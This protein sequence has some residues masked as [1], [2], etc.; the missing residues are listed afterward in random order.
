[1][2]IKKGYKQTKAGVIPINWDSKS[3]ESITSK[4]GDGLHG[5]PNYSSTG[6]Y[7][8]I[9]GNN[10]VDGKIEVTNETKMVDNQEFQKHRKTL[11]DKSILLSINGTIG[12][13]AL[14]YGEKIIL[15]KSAAY[16][17][18]K[19][20]ISREF[21]YYS[22]QTLNVLNQF[23]DGLTG[24]TIGNLGL[25][26]IRNT[27]IPLPQP[28]EQLAISSALND[29]DKLCIGLNDLIKKKNNLKKAMMQALLNG[30]NRIVGYNKKWIELPLKEIAKPQK[31]QLITKKTIIEG[32][33]PVIAGG[34]QPAYYHAFANRNGKTITISAS[35][36]SA[37]YIA[38]HKKPIFASDCSTII[39][40][41]TYSVNF[42]YYALL[43][44]QKEIFKAQTGGAQPH[45]QPKDLEPILIKIPKDIKEQY[46]IAKVLSDID[47]EISKI[48]NLHN[49]FLNLKKA[50]I[51]ELL[52]GKTRLMKSK[53]M[54]A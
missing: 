41:D 10:L 28:T 51:Q 39:E 37:G 27:H 8:F 54:N 15:G 34:K 45:I 11:T 3:L 32:D 35:G 44:K 24:S 9:N 52:T 50:M 19:S 38:F 36:A 46:A 22:L 13:L 30:E 29:I 18:V 5:T 43:L 6:T 47:L 49:K 14:Y 33:I 17:N 23:F 53:K 16:L 48:K 2:E 7:S 26:A 31:G 25:S 20:K 12:N 4:I 42:L 21:I 40:S 1:M